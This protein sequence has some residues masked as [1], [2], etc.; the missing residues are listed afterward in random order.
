MVQEFHLFSTLRTDPVLFARI[1]QEAVGRYC[2]TF[3][4][5][6]ERMYVAGGFV[7]DILCG[8][9]PRDIDI[10]CPD[11]VKPD[12]WRVTRVQ[13][14]VVT[15]DT[16]VDSIPVQVMLW[17]TPPDLCIQNFDFTVCAAAVVF[18]AGQQPVFVGNPMFLEDNEH[19]KLRIIRLTRPPSTRQRCSRFESLG[20]SQL[21]ETRE[22]LSIDVYD[23]A[24]FITP[25]QWQNMRSLWVTRPT[26]DGLPITIWNE[27]GLSGF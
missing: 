12:S 7:R 16:G 2:P 23:E 11:F 5:H 9:E 8:R 25:E 3:P 19:G 18:G 14:K 24:T 13:G 26:F 27:S 22:L 17:S 10:Y 21:P 6:Q 4:F 1:V 20:Y 15:Y